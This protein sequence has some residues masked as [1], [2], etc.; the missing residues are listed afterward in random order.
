MFCWNV[1]VLVIKS[2]F[3]VHFVPI[4]KTFEEVLVK[5]INCFVSQ[6]FPQTSSTVMVGVMASRTF[7]FATCCVWIRETTYI[8]HWMSSWFCLRP[9][10]VWWTK[11]GI[12][13]SP[14]YPLLAVLPSATGFRLVIRAYVTDQLEILTVEI[15]TSGLDSYF[16]TWLLIGWQLCCQP[17]RSHV[18][19]LLLG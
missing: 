8:S 16:I 14:L 19:I 5:F 2:P 4:R 18:R 13:C 6:I 3:L 12:K 10:S 9:S 17:I 15:A 1:L 11:L 7:V